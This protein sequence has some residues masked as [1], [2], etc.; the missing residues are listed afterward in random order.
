MT[1]HTSSEH[2]LSSPVVEVLPT[3]PVTPPPRCPHLLPHLCTR[4]LFSSSSSLVLLLLTLIFYP[5]SS[6]LI[7]YPPIPLILPS[8]SFLLFLFPPLSLYITGIFPF[9]MI[10][11]ARHQSSQSPITRN[12]DVSRSPFT[13]TPEPI[14]VQSFIPRFLMHTLPLINGTDPSV[15]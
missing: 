15:Q 9:V 3:A 10:S 14:A 6:L 5:L 1:V 2:F 4:L 7:L 8:S 12:G 11:L 13:S